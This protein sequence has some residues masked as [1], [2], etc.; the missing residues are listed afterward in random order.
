MGNPMFSCWKIGAAIRRDDDLAEALKNEHIKM[1]FFLNGNIATLPS[2]IRKVKGAGRYSLV[3]LDLMEGVGRDHAGINFLARLGVDGVI[4]TRPELVRLGQKE[5]LVTVQRIFMLDSEALKTSIRTALSV[6]PDA[7]EILP[8][9][10]PAYVVTDLRESLHIPILA[11]GLL[12]TEDDVR[13]VLKK[14]VDMISTSRKNL[15]GV[16]P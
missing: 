14:G 8:A 4:S 7:V 5:K 11:G 6:K 15:W 12:L 2:L 10:V 16:M 1:F 13:Q 3:H 9:T